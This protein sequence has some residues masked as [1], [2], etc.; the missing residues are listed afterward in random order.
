MIALAS[1]TSGRTVTRLRKFRAIRLIPHSGTHVAGG[2]PTGR[3]A[4]CHRR[5][6]HVLGAAGNVVLTATAAAP[7]PA[8]SAVH[9]AD[10]LLGPVELAQPAAVQR[11]LPSEEMAGPIVH[12]ARHPL[13]Q[14]RPQRRSS[15][16]SRTT[17]RRMFR[18]AEPADGAMPGGTDPEP[19]T[20]LDRGAFAGRRRPPVGDGETTSG[21]QQRVSKVNP[22]PGHSAGADVPRARPH[23]TSVGTPRAKF[24]GGGWS[25]YVQSDS[26]WWYVYDLGESRFYTDNHL[27]ANAMPPSRSGA[28]TTYRRALFVATRMCEG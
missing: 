24:K 17:I 23:L 8:R 18:A 27:T 9:G 3:V 10:G 21:R 13:E 20:P 28:H 2:A 14:V 12:R 26:D 16:I 6:P 15:T 1:N 7:S 11:P 5:W 19:L 4:I 25:V 22:V